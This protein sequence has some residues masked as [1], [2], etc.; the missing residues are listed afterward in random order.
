MLQAANTDLFNT[1]V[2]N[3]HNSECPNLLFPLQF[4][5]EKVSQIYNSRNFLPF[6]P[7]G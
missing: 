7:M 6:L 1:L 2:P 4:K 5:T 3:F